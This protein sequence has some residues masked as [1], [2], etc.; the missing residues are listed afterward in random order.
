MDALNQALQSLVD[1]NGVE[2]D[3]IE[4]PKTISSKFFV[5]NTEVSELMN[6]FYTQKENLRYE[7][8]FADQYDL[9]MAR[10]YT[11]NLDQQHQCS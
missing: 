11:K 1:T 8:E 9:A 3:Y 6:N 2:F 7:K 10:E 4:L 5:S